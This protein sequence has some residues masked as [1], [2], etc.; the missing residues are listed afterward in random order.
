MVPAPVMALATGQK[1]EV[2]QGDII[3][4]EG[5]SGHSTGFH[6]HLGMG[7]AP[8]SDTWSDAHTV[9]PEKVLPG[10]DTLPHDRDDGPAPTKN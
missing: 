7:D 3:G 1:T 2:K 10:V 4:F 5:T 8:G 6:L 9:N